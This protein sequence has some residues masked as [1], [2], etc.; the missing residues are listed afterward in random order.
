[1]ITRFWMTSLIGL[2]CWAFFSHL[3]QAQHGIVVWKEKPHYP[4]ALAQVLYFDRAQTKGPVTWYYYGG[5]RKRFDLEQKVEYI[6]LPPLSLRETTDPNEI[7]LLKSSRDEIAKFANRFPKSKNYL[8]PYLAMYE[9]AFTKFDAGLVYSK[10][11]WMSPTT[12][13]EVKKE[14]A[15]V[16]AKK[17]EVLKKKDDLAELKR[18]GIHVG[19]LLIFLILLIF[20]MV[21]KR[22]KLA[23]VMILLPALGAGWIYYK[24]RNFKPIT[25]YLQTIKV[26]DQKALELLKE[27]NK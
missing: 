18:F 2:F 11:R 21:T 7:K 5:Q 26:P 8:D 24:H 14:T 13:T 9:D 20:F 16:E 3:A 10:G 23:F 19:G 15:V 4:D 6:L 1:M 12:L 17:M 27:I 25:N 22:G